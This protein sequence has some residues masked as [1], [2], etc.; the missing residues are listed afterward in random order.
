[1]PR[2]HWAGVRTSALLLY[3]QP[4]S[5]H[6]NCVKG[7]WDLSILLVLDTIGASL[8]PRSCW[9]AIAESPTCQC[10][11]D[12]AKIRIYDRLHGPFTL[13]RFGV[14]F[15]NT[16]LCSVVYRRDNHSCLSPKVYC[17]SSYFNDGFLHFSNATSIC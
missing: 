8:Q 7:I 5:L 14:V 2:S 16:T 3:F 15:K 13:W 10:Q 12:S 9:G 6:L 17:E 1:M 11:S 4:F